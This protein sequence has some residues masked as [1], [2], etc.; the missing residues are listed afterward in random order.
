MIVKS[1]IICIICYNYEY[2]RF[3]DQIGYNFKITLLHNQKTCR[4]CKVL[5]SWGT[6]THFKGSRLGPR[7]YQPKTYFEALFLTIS[8]L[9]LYFLQVFWLWSNVVLKL[10]TIWCGHPV[11]IRYF[12]ISWLYLFKVTLLLTYPSIHYYTIFPSANSL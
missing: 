4:N 9:S 12:V 11:Y 1:T 8:K 3:L 6:K 7:S 2:A 5:E 10:R